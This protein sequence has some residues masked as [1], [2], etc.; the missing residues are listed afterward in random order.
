MATS[1]VLR[2]AVPTPWIPPQPAFE[3]SL[4]HSSAVGNR[5]ELADGK[6]PAR[7]GRAETVDQGLG[8]AVQQ[9][10]VPAAAERPISGPFLLSVP[11][12]S[13]LCAYRL[14]MVILVRTLEARTFN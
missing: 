2:V 8:E 3:R 13:D 11:T 9:L 12:V 1:R 10:E 14:R 6:P 5:A 7:S 4:R